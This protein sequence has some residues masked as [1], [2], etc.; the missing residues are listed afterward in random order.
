[1]PH[2][3]LDPRTPIV[4]PDEV[5][6]MTYE[7]LSDQTKVGDLLQVARLYGLDM[8][9]VVWVD[10][11]VYWVAAYSPFIKD[12]TTDVMKFSTMTHGDWSVAF[13]NAMSVAT[14]IMIADTKAAMG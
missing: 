8:D 3:N 7:Q 12:G 9:V 1:M 13:D 4:E 2:T 6:V 5:E 11:D 14:A 10:V